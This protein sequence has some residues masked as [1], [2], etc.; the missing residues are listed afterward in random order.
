MFNFLICNKMSLIVNFS[1]VNKRLKEFV[2]SS[3]F[4]EIRLS[5]HFFY[6]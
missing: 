6:A 4:T 1:N 5:A 3:I 2:T